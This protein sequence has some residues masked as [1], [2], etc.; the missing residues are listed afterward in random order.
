MEISLESPNF[1]LLRNPSPSLKD[2]CRYMAFWVDAHAPARVTGINAGGWWPQVRSRDYIR[3]QVNRFYLHLKPES[4][5]TFPVS[6][7]RQSMNSYHLYQ[8]IKALLSLS[9]SVQSFYRQLFPSC[10]CAGGPQGPA[11]RM[12]PSFSL[13]EL[14]QSKIRGQSSISYRE[15][16]VMLLI[17]WYVVA[18]AL[19]LVAYWSNDPIHKAGISFWDWTPLLLSGDTCHV[20][21]D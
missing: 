6:E 9:S 16:V 3:N 14:K 18:K 4:K 17:K 10:V 2:R 7:P 8:S 15:T 13:T 5:M 19:W 12:T 1:S 21:F 20:W 11:V